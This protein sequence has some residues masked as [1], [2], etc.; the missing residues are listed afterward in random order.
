MNQ[1]PISF[2]LIASIFMGASIYTMLS[3]KDC[4]PFIEYEKS[5]DETQH[6][7]YTKIVRE[8]VSIYITGLILGTILALLYLYLNNMDIDPF[9]HSCIFVAIALTTQ[10]LYYMLYPKSAYMVTKM[11]STDQLIKWQA[12]N[13]HMQYKYHMGM[14]L[15]I[16][17]YF[18]LSYGLN[19]NIKN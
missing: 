9:K 13:K 4:P 14:L 12:I 16:I 7:E 2:C 1:Q 6:Q 5:L 18:F 8:R 3:C 11:K 10:Y 15:G 19:K 17:G